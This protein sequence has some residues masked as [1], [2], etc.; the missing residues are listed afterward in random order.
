VVI[1]LSVWVAHA[2]ILGGASGWVFDQSASLRPTRAVTQRASLF[3]AA[4]NMSAEEIHAELEAAQVVNRDIF[5]GVRAIPGL[6]DTVAQS[7][8]SKLS[9][10]NV[11]R[12][13]DNDL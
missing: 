9:E 3:S 11:S 1:A 10:M 4:V 7:V 12:P 13:L 5:D 2:Q 8:D 6:M